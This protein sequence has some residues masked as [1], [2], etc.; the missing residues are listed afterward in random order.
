MKK[1]LVAVDESKHSKK[2][3]EYSVRE[4]EELDNNITVLTVVPGLG[5]AGKEVE[6]ALKEE[7]KSA[8]EY[9]SELKEEAEKEGVDINTDVITGDNIHS[10]IVKYAKDGDYDQIVVAGKGKS[11]LGTV[12]LGSVSEG[13]VKRAH[14]PVLI[15]R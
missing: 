13:V 11:D 2:A 7:I 15:V 3:F 5:Y 1:I 14:C 6:G 10:E 9:L 12:H 4:A 8:K